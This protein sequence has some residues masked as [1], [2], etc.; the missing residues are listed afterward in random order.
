MVLMLHVAPSLLGRLLGRLSSLGY[1]TRCAQ[2]LKLRQ[3]QTQRALALRARRD[4]HRITKCK[5]HGRAACGA[6]RGA[7]HAVQI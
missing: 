4:E 5:P 2:N 6:T 7:P 3:T 1:L